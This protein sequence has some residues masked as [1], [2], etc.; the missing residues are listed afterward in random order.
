M[1]STSICNIFLCFLAYFLKK[2]Q[3]IYYQFMKYEV[4]CF[5][6]KNTLQLVSLN[7]YEVLI[8]ILYTIVIVEACEVIF[9]LTSFFLRAT[10]KIFNESVCLYRDKQ[11]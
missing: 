10:L 3:E 1:V 7:F 9:P 8:L 5:L 11:L 6:N 2:P 4:L